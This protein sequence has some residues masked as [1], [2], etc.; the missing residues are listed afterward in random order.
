MHPIWLKYWMG[1]KVRGKRADI[2][3]RYII[4]PTEEQRKAY[5]AAY[6]RI[7][8]TPALDEKAMRISHERPSADS[9]CAGGK[10]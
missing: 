3:G 6:H 1:H 8:L 2:E 5:M 10:A 9:G 7:D 4:P